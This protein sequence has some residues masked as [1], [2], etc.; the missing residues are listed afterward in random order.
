[1]I[2]WLYNKHACVLIN[3]VV[4]KKCEYRTV[5]KRSVTTTARNKIRLDIAK[6]DWSY[7]DPI[8]SH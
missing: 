6:I 2:E 7:L 1:M 5:C 4:L 3:D 8:K